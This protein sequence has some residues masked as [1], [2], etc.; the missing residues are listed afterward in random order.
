M[1]MRWFVL[2]WIMVS[3]MAG[4]ALAASPHEAFLKRQA[5]LQRLLRERMPSVPALPGAQALA[6]Q[7]P[8][9]L[10]GQAPRLGPLPQMPQAGQAPAWPGLFNPRA[11]Q[12]APSAKSLLDR[13]TGGG[14]PDSLLPN[15]PLPQANAPRVG[16]LRLA[17]PPGLNAQRVSPNALAGRLPPL[18]PLPNPTAQDLAGRARLAGQAAGMPNPQQFAVDKAL[19]QERQFSWAAQQ[20]VMGQVGGTMGYDP[21]VGA[22]TPTFMDRVARDLRRYLPQTGQGGGG[23]GGGRGVWNSV[24]GWFQ[25]LLR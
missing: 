5:E 16:S 12:A 21:G 20:G 10:L 11:L 24:V 7:D 6:G 18:P 8:A 25:G 14:T 13:R 22:T 19:G 4:T 3:L 17:P 2:A 15:Q 9:P 1:L 23:S